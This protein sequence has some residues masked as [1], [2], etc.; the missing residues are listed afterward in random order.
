MSLGLHRLLLVARQEFLNG[1]R[2]KWFLIATFGLPLLMSGILG[3]TVAFSTMGA[4]RTVRLV[5]V[6]ESGV[7][8]NRLARQFP[9]RFEAG[10]FEGRRRV[11]IDTV[12]INSL[13]DVEH[14]METLS[15]KI[16]AREIDGFVHL[17]KNFIETGEADFFGL[18]V[19]N[20]ELN[21]RLE[22]ALSRLLRQAR[23]TRAGISEDRVDR[24][25]EPAL[26]ETFR[27]SVSGAQ[28]DNL[29]TFALVYVLVLLLYITVVLYGARIGRSVLEEKIS[30]IVEVMLSAVRPFELLGGKVLGVGAVGLLQTGVWGVFGLAL[31]VLRQGVFGEMGETGAYIAQM[32]DFPLS[33]VLHFLIWFL[34][35]Y[36]LYALLYALIA[37][38][39]G[40]EREAEQMQAPV[41][42]FLLLPL[43]AQVA[44]IKNPDS[45]V[46]VAMSMFPFFAPIVMFMRTAVLKPPASEIALSMGICAATILLMLFLTARIYRVGILSSGRRPSLRQLFRW[47]LQG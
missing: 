45:A 37:S 28:R 10:E 18:T 2:S 19:S 26:L 42:L 17:E 39:A 5:L 35:G 4:D 29:Q 30:R 11:E 21:M 47:F 27:V 8:G 40:S 46:A 41:S 44:V 9:E 1:V 15:E 16:L 3:L 31:M 32:P 22:Q 13:V 14:I 43:V 24:L 20:I 34:L 33:L 6:D 36:F 12:S 23:L 7:V 25:L 38:I